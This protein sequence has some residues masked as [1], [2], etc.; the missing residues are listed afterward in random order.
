MKTTPDLGGLKWIRTMWGLEPRWS[1]ELDEDAIKETVQAALHLTGIFDIEFLAKGVFNRLYTLKSADKELVARV[2]LPIDPKWKT[3]SEVATMQWVTQNTSLPVPRVLA[4]NAVRS[5][6]IGFEWI[7]MDK[8]PGKPWADIWQSISFG[9]K[10]KIVCQVALF[11]SNTF[12]KQMTGIGSL[13][14]HTDELKFTSTQLNKTWSPSASLLEESSPLDSSHDR[15]PDDIES[16]TSSTFHLGRTVSTSFITRAT[17]ANVSY[18]PFATGRDWLCARLDVAER[19][20]RHR[21]AIVK[22]CA[23]KTENEQQ[24]QP[25]HMQTV[26]KTIREDHNDEN[27]DRESDQPEQI[28]QGCVEDDIDEVAKCFQ[29]SIDQGSLSIIEGQVIAEDEDPELGSESDKDE[30]DEEEDLEDLENSLL[31]IAKL[32]NQLD[33]FFPKAQPD[34]SPEPS[35]IFHDDLSRHNILIDE[36]GLLSAVVDWECVSTLPL[37]IACQY[38]SFLQGHTLDTEPIK[39]KYQH[40]EDGEV[41]ELYWEHLENYELTQLR[42]VFLEEMQKL[43]PGWVKVFYSSKRQRDYVLALEAFDDLFM[44]RRILSWLEDVESEKSVFPGLEDRIDAGTL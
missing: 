4:Y 16:C 15:E 18:G 41:T 10:T 25:K 2:T 5:N 12:Q 35:M 31:I 39:S 36:N 43:Q 9:A 3:L 27:T 26:T 6:P 1:V 28:N 38:P 44:I 34:S 33:N 42:R 20:C 30:D 24:E 32:R 40:D 22:R 7:V 29:V 8:V 11:C 17:H 19:D 37:S 23:L 21:L 14:K 13:F